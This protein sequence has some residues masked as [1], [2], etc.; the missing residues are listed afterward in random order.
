MALEF[1]RITEKIRAMGEVAEE[2]RENT[3][4]QIGE[5]LTIL[6]NHASNWAYIDRC[7]QRALEVVD[8]QKFRAARPLFETEPMDQGIAPPAKTP[9]QATL[10]AIDGSQALPSRH[11][12]HLYYVI[13]TGTIV[14]HHG[15]GRTPE[16]KTQ[17]ELFYLGDGVMESAEDFVAGSV[18]IQRDMAE[19]NGLVE[20]V[21]EQRYASAPII[22]MLDQRLQYFPIGVNQR[23]KADDYMGRWLYG[24]ERIKRQNAWLVG[25]IERP[26]TASVASLLTVLGWGDGDFSPQDSVILN[27]RPEM[28]DVEIFAALLELGERSC[29]FEVVNESTNYQPFQD[30]N[31][32]ICFF[33]YRP[34]GLGDVTRVDVPKWAAQQPEVIATIHALLHDQCL[35]LGGYPYVLSR[36][37]EAAVVQGSDRE[38]L[39]HL[40]DL[41]MRRRGIESRATVKQMGK[42]W[43]RAGKGRHSV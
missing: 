33:Y 12:P 17:P 14:Y 7:L 21:A 42:D 32:H 38:Y 43:S 5:L 19:I 36:A 25:Y 29:V 4:V 40:I 22:A 13:N 39:E 2:R 28:Q 8:K 6:Y 16:E 1:E 27:E 18:S 3:G 10:I 15:S 34:P 30:H 35:L 11:A 9:A 37:D 41:E 31:Q 23:E 24:M 20:A 26:L